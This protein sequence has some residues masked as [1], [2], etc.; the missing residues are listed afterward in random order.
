M[1]AIVPLAID[2]DTSASIINCNGE[3]T[4]SIVATAT[5]GL[6]NYNYELLDSPTSTTPLQGPQASGTFSGLAVGN[7]YIKVTSD[8]GCETVSPVIPITEPT[9]LQIDTEEFTNVSCQGQ[10]DG[11]ITVAV[12]GGT[13]VMKYAITPNLNQFDTKNVFTDLEPGVYD[14]IAQDENGCFI[15]FQFTIDEPTAIV[16]DPTVVTDETCTGSEDGTVSVTI[17]GGTAPYSTSLDSNDPNDYVLNQVDFTGLTSGSHVILV[18]DANGCDANIVVEIGMGVNLNATVTPVYECTGD[19]PSNSLDVVFEDPSVTPDVL[20]SLDSTD[21]AAMR[22]DADYIDI[23][24]GDHTLYITHANGCVNTIDFTIDGFTPLTLTVQNSNI[25]EITAV[26]D[27]GKPNYTFYFDDNDN[28]SDNVFHVNRSDTYTVRVVDE[29]GCESVQEIEVINELA[30]HQNK[31][32]RIALRLNPN[33]DAKTHKYITTGLEENKFGINSWELDGLIEKLPTWKHINLTGLHFHIGSQITDLKPF[34]NLCN[35]INELQQWFLSRNVKI[36]HINVGGGLGIDY[37]TP[38]LHPLPP[39][40]EYFK[41]FHDFLELQPNQDVHFE[42]GRS[43]TG[44][45]G[46]LVSQVLYVKKGIN[47]NFLILDAGMTE[48][49][50]PALYQSYHKIENLSKRHLDDLSREKYDV[51]GPI[52]ESS[53]CFGKNVVLQQTERGDL[54]GIRSAGAYGEVMASSYNLRDK[55]KVLF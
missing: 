41:I 22:L 32:A 15:P 52:C 27:G 34:K 23:T 3:S 12:S 39:Y 45:M 1:D 42:L 20:Y 30:Q 36:K 2:L 24:A 40:E 31:I 53:D 8:G 6:G 18:K 11:T 5:G 49:I 10:N 47:T 4:A 50:R 25:N 17:T 9:P 55:A 16:I 37:Q 28:G 43:I 46:T 13:G 7:Y 21:P 54:I 29:N 44:T 35:K 38:D 19:T 51:V 14:V 26:A 48:L 33:V